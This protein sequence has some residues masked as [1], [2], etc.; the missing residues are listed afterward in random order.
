MLSQRRQI[1]WR[2]LSLRWWI[3]L[4]NYV[5]KLSGAVNPAENTSDNC[6][7]NEIKDVFASP[8]YNIACAHTCTTIILFC[9][10]WMI[11]SI[12][13]HIQTRSKVHS[14]RWSLFISPHIRTTVRAWMCTERRQYDASSKCLPNI[15]LVWNTLTTQLH[16]EDDGTHE[17]PSREAFPCICQSQLFCLVSEQRRVDSQTRCGTSAEQANSI[18]VN[19]LSRQHTRHF[20]RMQTLIHLTQNEMCGARALTALDSLF[21]I[22]SFS[23]EY[24]LHY[25]SVLPPLHSTSLRWVQ[26]GECKHLAH[27]VEYV[28]C[29]RT[30]ARS[31]ALTYARSLPDL[32]HETFGFAIQ[33]EKWHERNWR[34]VGVTTIALVHAS[35]HAKCKVLAHDPEYVQSVCRA[36]WR[37]RWMARA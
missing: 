17:N 28:Q 7:A 31:R 6:C 26:C 23:H 34:N 32:L 13:L 5:N 11:I 18:E 24:C 2:K 19:S 30:S 21:S 1:V 15:R 29:V 14:L 4:K 12:T 37:A 8:Y 27:D 33:S 9:F 22:F 25:L 3:H 20:H 36:E 35:S 10:T 16:I